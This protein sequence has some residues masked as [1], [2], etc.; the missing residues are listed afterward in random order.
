MRHVLTQGRL[1][2]RP[3]SEGGVTDVQTAPT[4]SPHAAPSRCL[5]SPSPLPAKESRGTVSSIF[6]KDFMNSCCPV[7]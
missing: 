6:D 5:P 4:T 7:E 2:L 1:G 3:C